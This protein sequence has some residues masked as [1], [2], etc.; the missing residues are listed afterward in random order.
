MAMQHLLR[1]PDALHLAVATRQNAVFWTL[2]KTLA[3]AAKWVGLRT[4]R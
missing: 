1:A 2:D 3:K 4:R